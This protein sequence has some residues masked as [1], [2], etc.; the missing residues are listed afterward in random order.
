M[1]LMVEEPVG[2]HRFLEEVRGNGHE[3]KCCG[4]N[5]GSAWDT[6]GA[7]GCDTEAKR[8]IERAL[9]TRTP[10]HG[11]YVLHHLL[12]LMLLLW[13]VTSSSSDAQTMASREGFDRSGGATT[14]SSGVTRRRCGPSD[15]DAG[16]SFGA[17][18]GSDTGSTASAGARATGPGT[19]GSSAA[20]LQVLLLLVPSLLVQMLSLVVVVFG[21]AEESK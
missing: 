5:D 14:C 9:Q 17:C 16:V 4:A 12:L 13:H 19:G 8:S 15:A 1:D 6:N 21:V 11:E 10:L 20:R 18:H 3:T 2:C 7:V